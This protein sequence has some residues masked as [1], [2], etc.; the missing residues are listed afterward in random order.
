MCIQ[1][2]LIVE[3]C[4]A[5]EVRADVTVNRRYIGLLCSSGIVVIG[6]GYDVVGGLGFLIDSRSSSSMN[7]AAADGEGEEDTSGIASTDW[8]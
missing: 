5:G 3:M 4:F 8:S 1:R 7:C 6:D 2:A